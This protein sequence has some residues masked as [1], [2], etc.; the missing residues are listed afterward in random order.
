MACCQ[1]SSHQLSNP[2]RRPPHQACC[3]RLF[4]RSGLMA[5]QLG[6]APRKR[7]HIGVKDS[8]ATPVGVMPSESTLAPISLLV[9]RLRTC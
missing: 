3:W 8:L 6:S 9:A 7:N 4:G 1:P 2:Y 5:T